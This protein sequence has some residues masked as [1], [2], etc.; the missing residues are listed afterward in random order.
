MD[1]FALRDHLIQDYYNY[2][3]LVQKEKDRLE[4]DTLTHGLSPDFGRE[5]QAAPVEVKAPRAV[6]ENL[7]GA[8][9]EQA[10]PLPVSLGSDFGLQ[11]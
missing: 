1:V 10:E 7:L 4:D 6:K 5:E 2:I 8:P 11:K 3:G 9:A